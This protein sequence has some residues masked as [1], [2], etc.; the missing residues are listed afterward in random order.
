MYSVHH[1]QMFIQ[2]FHT[3]PILVWSHFFTKARTKLKSGWS[4]VEKIGW[5]INGDWIGPF[6]E[7]F[8]EVDTDR[9]TVFFPSLNLV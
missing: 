3:Q 7:L 2:Y 6:T 9:E 4:F 8:F 5:S 1:L